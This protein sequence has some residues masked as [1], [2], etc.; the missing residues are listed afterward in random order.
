VGA[1]GRQI[2]PRQ[3][4]GSTRPLDGALEPKRGHGQSRSGATGT[5]HGAIE[6]GIVSRQE[7]HAFADE[8]DGTLDRRSFGRAL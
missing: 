3:I 5:E 8:S 6:G 1:H 2:G 4:E 7:V